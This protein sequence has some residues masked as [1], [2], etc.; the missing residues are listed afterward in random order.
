M[1]KI[2]VIVKTKKFMKD[3]IAVNGLMGKNQIPKRMRN[4]KPSSI[5]IRDNIKGRRK[6]RIILHEL[7]EMKYLKKGIP[8][9]KAYKKA[10][11]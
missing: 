2:N 8:Y 5:Y 4:I 6:N 11:Y 3:Y 7:R 10:K 9:K 1:T